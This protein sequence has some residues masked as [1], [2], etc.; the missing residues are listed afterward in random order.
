MHNDTHTDVMTQNG[1]TTQSVNPHL[2]QTCKMSA[3]WIKWAILIFKNLSL[4][5]AFPHLILNVLLFLQRPIKM[6]VLGHLW[7]ISISRT[8]HSKLFSD[9]LTHQARSKIQNFVCFIEWCLILII[10]IITTTI[11]T[12]L[13]SLHWVNNSKR[14]VEQQQQ[15]QQQ[16]HH[17]H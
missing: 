1:D 5:C 6:K 10:L 11:L 9:L 17:H 2:S 12:L 4:R 13:Q 15:Q 14:G 3:G 7:K 16:Q 8:N